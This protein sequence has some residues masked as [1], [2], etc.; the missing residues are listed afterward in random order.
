MPMPAVEISLSGLDV[1]WRRLE[2]IA[3]NLANMN[4]VR[5]TGAE[6]YQPMR[7]VSGPGAS[8]ASFLQTGETQLGA[9]GVQVLSLEQTDAG[10]TASYEPDHPLAG[11]DGLIW[12]PN[13]DHASE[14]SLML[15]T[16][17]TYEANLTAV[18]LAQ[19]MYQRAL[20]AGR[21]R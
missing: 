21:G 18:A 15:R 13:V 12:R 1:E 6:G 5:A 2:V 4:T 20:D 8:F 19:Q 3:A 7:L 10:E 9:R 17:R 16:S 11:E 14:M